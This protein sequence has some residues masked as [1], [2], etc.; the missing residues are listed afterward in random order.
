MSTLNQIEVKDILYDIEDKQAREE[1]IAR[2]KNIKDGNVKY[3]IGD[4]TVGGMIS[5]TSGVFSVR[6]DTNL[7]ASEH[8]IPLYIS[9]TYEVSTTNAGFN[10]YFYDADKNFITAQ[11]VPQTTKK[12]TV[13]FD[14]N[15]YHYARIGSWVSGGMTQDKFNTISFK[16]VSNFNLEVDTTLT[17]SGVP[18]DSKTVGEKIE[19]LR[20]FNGW[21]DTNTGVYIDTVNKKLTFG[22]NSYITYGNQLFNMSNTTHDISTMIGGSWVYLDISTQPYKLTK[23]KNSSYV[24]LLGALW[25]PNHLSDLHMDKTK[26]FIDGMPVSYSGRYHN[27]TIN[28]LGDSM[29]EGVGTTKA[30]HQWFGQLCGFKT[31]NNYGVGGSSIS[32][33]TDDIPTWD[34]FKSFYERYGEMGEAD[35]I[36]VFGGV[37]DWVTGRELGKISDTTSNTFYGAMKLLCQGL[38]NKYPTSDIFVFSSPQCD[39]VN[40]PA[41]ELGGTEWAG[42]TE[43]YNRKGYKLQDY[44]NAMSEVCSIYGIPFCSLT[45]NLFYGLSGVLGDHKGTSGA[46]GTD[47]L[48]PNAEGHKKIALKM[49]T[50]INGGIGSR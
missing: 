47:A 23:D 38:I 36:T 42:N 27:K 16:M 40:R 25:K 48:H 19:F 12:D 21:I 44:T 15:E 14:N 37:N 35:V 30:Y 7:G 50:V 13:I 29:T 11:Y 8:Y 39:Y 22:A 1:I 33:K 32:P 31:I 45:N 18:A 28:C 5:E 20:K 49:A 34:T 3:Y 9:E 6:T 17:L 24:I 2:T 41:S 43:G 10:I 4:V 46:Y 26:L